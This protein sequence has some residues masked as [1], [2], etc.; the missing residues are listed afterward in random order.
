[1]A[2]TPR[3]RPPKR[4]PLADGEA[5]VPAP[6]AGHPEPGRRLAEL[7]RRAFLTRSVQ[8]GAATLAVG[9]VAGCSTSGRGDAATFSSGSST[10]TSTTTPTT[11]GSSTSAA[12]GGTS[13]TTGGAAG[14]LA[15]SELTVRF[16]YT[17]A[18][19]GG[20]IQN[21]YVAVWIEDEAGAL[22]KALGLWFG[23]DGEGSRYLNELRRWYSVD[24]SQDTVDTVS[25][26]TRTPGDFSLVWDGTAHDGS[27]APVGT[28]FTCIEAAREHGPYSLIR[29]SVDLG[30][31]DVKTDLPDDGELS[32]ASVALAA[33]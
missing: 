25:S 5:A 9:L 1:M 4:A 28:Y 30:T 18:D 7:S 10:T 33:G 3:S 11:A 17:T 29:Q 2:R 19:A 14:T 24:G 31:T 23:Q 27:A 15:G 22:V 16:T 13:P 8:A 20:R 12:S 26:A 21:P 32:G 6:T